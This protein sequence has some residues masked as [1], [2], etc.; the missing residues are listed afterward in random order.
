MEQ[1]R[2]FVSNGPVLTL[3]V[4]G[5]DP[6]ARLDKATADGKVHIKATA[7]SQWPLQKLVL[8]YNGEE[9]DI[10]TADSDKNRLILEG[11][12]S[13]PQ[14]GWLA[15]YCVGPHN[16]HIFGGAIFKEQV[17]FAHTSPIWVTVD[18]KPQPPSADAEA[19]VQWVDDFTRMVEEKGK[20]ADDAQRIHMREI[21]GK[22]RD[23][24]DEKAEAYRR[25]LEPRVIDARDLPDLR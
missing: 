14:S 16:R 12:V 15:A 6:G 21:F 3:T 1:G 10:I 25:T 5:A 17:Q 13:I 7:A 24:C 18:G 8:L 23:V 4:D 11:R 20:F 9:A 2:T 19:L 22:A